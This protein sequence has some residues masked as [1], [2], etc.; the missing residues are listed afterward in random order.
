MT[1]IPAGP[2]LPPAQPEELSAIEPGGRLVEDQDPGPANEAGA[3][4]EAAAHA[5]PNRSSPDGPL[6]P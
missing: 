1:A 6:P 2:A 4:V 5:L 3:K